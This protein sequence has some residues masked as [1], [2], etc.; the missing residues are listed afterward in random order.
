MAV[1]TLLVVQTQY[2]NLLLLL[3]VDTVDHKM[4]RQFVEMELMV[5]VE[6]EVVVLHLEQ[7]QEEIQLLGKV[8]LVEMVMLV[9]LFS[10]VQGVEAQLQL[11]QTTL[12][13]M[14]VM[15]EMELQMQLVHLVMVTA[16]FML[17]VEVGVQTGHLIQQ[18]LVAQVEAVMELVPMATLLQ[19]QELVLLIVVVVEVEEELVP[20]DSVVQEW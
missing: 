16:E 3:V 11:V 8:M 12:V 14:V 4:E 9:V 10:R 20:V 17:V 6:A 19:L 7:R 18:V 1:Q 13:I 2:G 5:E 15:V